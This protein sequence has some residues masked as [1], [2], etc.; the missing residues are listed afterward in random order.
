[1][2]IDIVHLRNSTIFNLSSYVLIAI[3]N[4]PFSFHLLPSVY[5]HIAIRLLSMIVVVVHPQGGLGLCAIA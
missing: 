3:M 1:M 4:Y 2:Q 5:I